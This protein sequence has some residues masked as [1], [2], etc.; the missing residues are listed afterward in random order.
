M[1]QQMPITTDHEEGSSNRT[2]LAAFA[3]QQKPLPQRLLPAD[4]SPNSHEVN[5]NGILY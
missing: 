3:I 5:L 2:P 1:A 4:K